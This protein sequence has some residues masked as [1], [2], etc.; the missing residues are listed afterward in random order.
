MQEQAADRV[1]GAP[2]VIEQLGIVGIA[3][4]GHV[5]RE[6][7]EQVAEQLQ[8]KAMFPH[9][10]PDLVEQR[11]GGRIELLAVA[12]QLL[13]AYFWQVVA[14]VGEVVGG[15][16]E[17]IDDLDRRAQRSRKEERC[18]REIFVMADRHETEKFEAPGKKR[19][20]QRRY[21]TLFLSAF[22]GERGE[23]GEGGGIGR[24]TRF[25]FWR[26]EA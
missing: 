26:R 23:R 1:G 19:K 5:L 14:F 11:L 15:A 21:N 7:V 20:G 24:R 8:R 4:L 6:G 22:L 17:A 2:A 18:H 16:R 9:D 13:Q 10:F 25:R 3:L 12:L